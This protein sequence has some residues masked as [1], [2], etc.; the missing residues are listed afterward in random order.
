MPDYLHWP[1]YTKGAY[2]ANGWGC[3]DKENEREREEER[4][5]CFIKLYWGKEAGWQLLCSDRGV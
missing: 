3:V 2:G 1:T 4:Y 5:G